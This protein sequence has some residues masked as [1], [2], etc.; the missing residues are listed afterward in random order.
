MYYLIQNR[1]NLLTHTS[2]NCIFKI[3]I[4]D[5]KKYDY[6]SNTIKPTFPDGLD[7][8]A[9]SFKVLL[10]GCKFGTYCYYLRRHFVP[11]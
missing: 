3:N 5:K 8:E 4:Y 9:F 10:F 11:L 2:I 1:Y 6:I 7:V